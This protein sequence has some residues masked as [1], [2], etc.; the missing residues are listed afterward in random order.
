MVWDEVTKMLTQPEMVLSGLKA[1]Q[2]ATDELP[3]LE[4]ELDDVKRQIDQI[5][6]RKSRVVRVFELDGDEELLK[7]ELT[8][9]NKEKSVLLE[10]KLQFEKKIELAG[11]VDIDIENLVKYCEKLSHNTNALCFD[12]KRW[13][14]DALNIKVMIDGCDV[15]I[16]GD[17]PIA[18]NAFVS[19]SSK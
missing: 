18:E 15:A 19:T 12:D 4:R 6:V 3:V 10:S 1:K 14:I 9:L 13:V 5:E 16:Q 17:I 8:F 2:L 7:K 11:Q